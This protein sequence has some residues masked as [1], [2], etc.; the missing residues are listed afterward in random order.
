MYTKW[1]FSN[2][3]VS[4]SY[5]ITYELTNL[6]VL[7]ITYFHLILWRKKHISFLTLF[8][9]MLTVFIGNLIHYSFFVCALVLFVI[10]I[11][12]CVKS[13]NY[14]NLAR[15]ITFMLL[16]FTTSFLV[17]K[18]L[19]S[20]V[21]L[22]L[23]TTSKF[24]LFN[25]NLEK[26]KYI[27]IIN[28]GFFHK[29]FFLFVAIVGIVCY[30]KS[31]RKIKWNSATLIFSIPIVFYTLLVFMCSP[32]ITIKYLIPIYSVTLILILYMLKKFLFEHLANG[33]AIFVLILL[34]TIYAYNYLTGC[35]HLT[36]I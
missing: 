3:F 33:E 29:L 32:E 28:Y 25:V 30:K 20:H 1:V 27:T 10:Y 34:S 11:V 14:S 24:K 31:N 18:S 36:L 8:A 12:K 23:E 26:L 6:F 15:Y 2:F 4:S 9:I 22:G 16:G 17:G 21:L 13:R 7:L 35:L 5:P 19:Y